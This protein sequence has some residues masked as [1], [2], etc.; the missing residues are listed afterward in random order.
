MKRKT[1][2]KIVYLLALFYAGLT[3]FAWIYP[4]FF[5]KIDTSEVDRYYDVLSTG[6]KPSGN[7]I[8][9]LGVKE[10]SGL[11]PVV[12]R[13][14]SGMGLKDY[15][16]WIKY[17]NME[18][19]PAYIE[20]LG[21]DTVNIYISKNLKQRSEQINVLI[22]ELGHI[23]LW[24]LDDSFLNGCDEEKFNDCAGVFLGFGVLMLNGLTDDTFFIPGLE[25]RAEKKSFGYIRPEQIGYLLARYCA[26]RGIDADGV[27]PYLRPAGKK[28]FNIGRNYFKRC[29]PGAPKLN[30][31]K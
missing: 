15:N 18:K 5:M 13:I 19:P 14:K 30:S 24:D 16:M 17:T 9:E 23:Y 29:N 12:D 21:N 26:D 25:Y 22:H 2:K 1:I 31:K 20:K 27:I 7:L 8:L 6:S 4:N 10:D 3:A 28:Y 11:Q